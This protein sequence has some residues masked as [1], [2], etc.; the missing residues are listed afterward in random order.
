[1]T[2]FKHM[3]GR[4][5]P[6]SSKAVGMRISARISQYIANSLLLEAPYLVNMDKILRMYDPKGH[7]ITVRQLDLGLSDNY[8]AIL[9]RVKLSE[10]LHIIAHCSV[11][12]L[13]ELLKQAQQVGLMS[14]N[15][16]WFITNLDLHTVDLE[17]FMYGGT[18]ITGIRFFDPEDARL[19]QITNF[20]KEQEE[21]K[22]K[23]LSEGLQP[24]TLTTGVALMFDSVFLYAH[25]FSEL[26]E[27]RNFGSIDCEE[28]DGAHG[29]GGYSFLN[30]MK[31][32]QVRGLT[33]YINF[34]H[35]GK[36]T[37]FQLDVIELGSSGL[38]KVNEW[39][40]NFGV[41]SAR[42]KPPM[43][44]L[45]EEG[46]LRNRSFRVLTALVNITLLN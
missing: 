42:Q 5:S 17:P 6:F 3:V 46:S 21:E 41:T 24:S 25:A 19:Q 2:L 44:S 36:R 26:H 13:P 40:S 7:T 27:S 12:M 11:G 22:G 38:H 45:E 33:R 39:A 15:H 37:D 8:R 18:N 43:S 34:D 23:E 9:R 30:I 4:A 28:E 35:K 29:H 31:T 14:D 16:Y 20:W 1:M 10:E 32:L